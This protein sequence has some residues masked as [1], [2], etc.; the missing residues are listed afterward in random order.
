MESVPENF[1]DMWSGVG[2]QALCEASLRLLAALGTESRFPDDVDG[3]EELIRRVAKGR[4]GEALDFAV[5]PA[6]EL[7]RY[8]GKD[9]IWVS[10]EADDCLL[11]RHEYADLRSEA[12]VLRP[13][14]RLGEFETTVGFGV[15]ESE[16]TDQA[17]ADR[18]TVERLARERAAED[19]D[20]D[21]QIEADQRRFRT[22]HLRS[23]HAAP[24]QDGT[25]P[26]VTF[27]VL[28]DTGVIVH[29]LVARPPDDDLETDD[30]WAEPLIEAMLPRIE[31]SDPLGTA[32]EVVDFN[33]REANAPLLRA[34]QSFV[35]AVPAATERL[36][37]GFES[38]T[39]DIELGKR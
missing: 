15:P 34:S 32:Y 38:G 9:L 18:D 1:F 8:T 39:V 37:I 4:P 14:G 24:S 16:L 30:P 36:S 13:D 11:L 28:Y 12:V 10:P 6:G 29:Y 25:G 3:I 22:D 33:Q 27:I 23:V 31:L 17:R 21:R 7:P 2:R 19:V 35:P 20:I 5:E 26:I